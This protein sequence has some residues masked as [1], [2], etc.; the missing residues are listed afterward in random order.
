MNVEIGAEAAQFPEK[1]YINGIAVAVWFGKQEEMRKLYG[2]YNYSQRS[3]CIVILLLVNNYFNFRKEPM[4]HKPAFLHIGKE[5][6]IL[7]IIIYSFFLLF[8]I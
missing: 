4:C 5:V 3:T 6:I 2:H 8:V 7:T 1:E